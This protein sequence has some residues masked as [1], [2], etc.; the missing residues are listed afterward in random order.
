MS[1]VNTNKQSQ[2][3]APP[4]PTPATTPQ[5]TYATVIGE[6]IHLKGAV[7][8]NEDLVVLGRIDGSINLSRTLNVE[9]SGIV[10]ATIN[11]KNAVISGVVVGNITATDSVELLDGSR[12][13]GDIKSPRMIIVDGA[14]FSGA[15]DMGKL[16]VPQATR[17]AASLATQS[18]TTQSATPIRTQSNGEDTTYVAVEAA[19]QQVRRRVVVNRPR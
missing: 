17:P 3:K 10:K 13:V 5:E 4:P 18:T 12:V 15:I 2:A 14:L 16:D 19:E 8:G 7:Q 11:V 9:T 1:V 6:T